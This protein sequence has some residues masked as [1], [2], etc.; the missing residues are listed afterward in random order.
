MLIFGDKGALEL[1]LLEVSVVG[2]AKEAERLKEILSG[3]EAG[4]LP[5]LIGI[6]GPPGSG[7][8]LVTR[9]VCSDYET[10]SGGRFRF[11]YVNLGELKTVFACANRLLVEMGGRLK[12]GR[13]GIDGV[14]E[15]FWAR[16]V[17]WKGE[18]RKFLL[19]CMDEADRLFI[20]KRGDPSGFLYRLV[21]S[22][23]RL[24]GSG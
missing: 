8:T 9:K 17:E 23:D 4:F 21:R 6:H 20:D 22:Q 5:K 3:V 19:V 2:R 24:R 14:M 1:D 11:V 12:T 10:G 18:G 16:L 15:E 7:K 13:A